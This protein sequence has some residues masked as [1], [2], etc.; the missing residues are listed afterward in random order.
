MLFSSISNLFLKI[1]V[2]RG[3]FSTTGPG[4]F[5]VGFGSDEGE[6]DGLSDE[7]PFRG[8]GFSDETGEDVN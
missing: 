4:S 7:Y 1:L 6:V 8:F 3:L 5:W 2:Y